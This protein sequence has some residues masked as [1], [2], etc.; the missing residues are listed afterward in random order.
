MYVLAYA[1][2]VAYLPN[3]CANTFTYMV[4]Q[5]F[6]MYGSPKAVDP[7]HCK[8]ESFIHYIINFETFH[9][10]IFCIQYWNYC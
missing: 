8:H 7:W 10:S 6:P 2:T 5:N 9:P 3:F 4:C 1:L